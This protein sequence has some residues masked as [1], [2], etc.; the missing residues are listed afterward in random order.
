MTSGTLCAR[1]WDVDLGLASTRANPSRAAVILVQG[2]TFLLLAAI[3]CLPLPSGGYFLC[4]EPGIP[5]PGAA[6][7]I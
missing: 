2:W 6:F 4:Q 5:R 1:F 7:M 3:L